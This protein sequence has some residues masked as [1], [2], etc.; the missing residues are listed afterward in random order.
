MCLSVSDDT[1]LSWLETQVRVLEA[2]RE[3]VATRPSIDMRLVMSLEQ[4]YQWLTGQIEVLGQQR[5]Q[6]LRAVAG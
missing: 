5:P 2:W 1:M 4:H 3:D 6:H